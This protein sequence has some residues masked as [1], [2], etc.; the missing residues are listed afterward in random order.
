[1]SKLKILHICDIATCRVMK[2]VIAQQ[3]S[4]QF[5]PTL[6]YNRCWH[7][8][9]L[10]WVDQ[11]S[12]WGNPQHLHSKLQRLGGFDAY[13]VHTAID[14]SGLI[15]LARVSVPDAQIIWDLNDLNSDANE[16][17]QY[18]S[19]IFTPSTSMAGQLKTDTPKTV[20][21]SMLPQVLFPAI[22]HQAKR[23]QAGILAL[24]VGIDT[25]P[26][27]R[28]YRTIANNLGLYILAGNYKP[29]LLTHYNN[30]LQ[31]L[32]YTLMMQALTRYAYG[33]AGSANDRHDINTCVTNKFWEYIAAGIPVVTFKAA[34][35][36]SILTKIGWIHYDMVSADDE[37]YLI[38]LPALPSMHGRRFLYTMDN[39]L[40]AMHSAYTGQISSGDIDRAYLI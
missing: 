15:K 36:D 33:Y 9:L 20:I 1:M 38:K 26:I 32:P 37:P 14:N 22:V 7:R 12:I 6:L 5:E 35:M 31:T 24:G 21:Y 4:D 2:Q 29:E 40:G 28:D 8:D 16:Y 11:I 10:S 13:H 34:E 23:N 17:T 3:L 30:V 19:H 25:D 18:A 39:Q 27:W